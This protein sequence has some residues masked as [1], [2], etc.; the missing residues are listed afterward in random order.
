MALAE[1]CTPALLVDGRMLEANITAMA[2]WLSKYAPHVRLRPHAK[3]HK[4]PDIARRQIAAGA[5][6]VCCQ[7]VREAEAMAAGGVADILLT[8]QLADPVKAARLARLARRTRISACVDD[9]EQV[10]LLSDAATEAGVRLTA[11]VEL[12]VGGNRCGVPTARDAVLLAER[13]AESPGL[14]FGGLQA[15]H[16]RAQHF[17]QPE[18]RRTA[19]EQAIALAQETVEA[20]KAAGLPCDAVTGAGSG[21]F[22]FEAS[23]RV[24]TELQ[25]G[26]YVFMDADYARNQRDPTGSTPVFQQALTILS[27]VVSHPV[28]GHVICDAGLKAMSFDS[29]PPTLSRHPSLRYVGGSDEHSKLEADEGA[30]P[31]IGELVQFDPGHCDPTVAMH[32]WIIVHEDGFVKE[33]WPVARGW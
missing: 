15:Y 6:G 11:L 23:S 2:A 30:F 33:L 28:P 14:T 29:G 12:D 4:S 19:I 18:E 1:I 8:N 16:G 24:Y 25:C 26:S 31:P 17:R 32:E 27:R 21:S 3:T 20:L 10:G 13:I 7:T 5:I 9:V 22:E